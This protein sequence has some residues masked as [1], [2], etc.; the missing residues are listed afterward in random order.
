MNALTTKQAAELLDINTRNVPL[1]VTR[2]RLTTGNTVAQERIGHA[3]AWG[4]ADMQKVAKWYATDPRRAGKGF[5]DNTFAHTAE[6]DWKVRRRRTRYA[7]E[8]IK[9]KRGW[10]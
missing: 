10:A 7:M 9:A 6:T 1:V 3:W 4:E 8:Q 5:A 2:Y